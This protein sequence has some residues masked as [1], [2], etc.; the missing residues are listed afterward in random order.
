M[1]KSAKILVLGGSGFI[2]SNL[3][4]ELIL[5]SYDVVNLDIQFPEARHQ[6]PFYEYCDILDSNGLNEKIAKIAPTHVINLAA[7]TDLLGKDLADYNVNTLG[8]TN[9][10]DAIEQVK[11]VKRVVFV[12][13][14]L[15]CKMGHMPIAVDETSA[16]TNYGRSKYMGEEIVRERSDRLP[17]TAIVRP[18]SIW[19][20]YFKAPY[21]AFFLRVMAK[22]FFN[23]KGVEA[24]KTY[25]YVKNTVSELIA[26]LN[27][28]EEGLSRLIYIGDYPAVSVSLWS[29]R[30]A[31]HHSQSAIKE[32]PYPV[33][34]LAAKIGDLMAKINIEFPI[35]T[36][37]LKNMCSNY[38]LSCHLSSLAPNEELV[39]IDE[40]VKNT[41]DWLTKSEEH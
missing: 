3:M 14:M 41:L 6:I 35:T 30:I 37:R 29:N 27:S 32:L 10:C 24:K 20:P 21:K 33:F 39:N 22:K 4:D 9:I 28:E 38:D 40:G 8:V 5:R 16:D 34:F 23:I 36:F 13:S 12:S 15:V 11:S 26:L 18:T 2:G 17:S 1:F 25:G 19:G 7:R 31:F